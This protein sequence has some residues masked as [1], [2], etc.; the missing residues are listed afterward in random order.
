[1]GI[2]ISI[3]LALIISFFLFD[4]IKAILTGACVLCEYFKKHRH[5]TH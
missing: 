4:T 1:M 5:I 3:V 2:F